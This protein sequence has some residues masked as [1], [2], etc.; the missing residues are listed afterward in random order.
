VGH[1]HSDGACGAGQ[2]QA[3]AETRLF[4]RHPSAP[5]HTFSA[6]AGLRLTFNR[7]HDLRAR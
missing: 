4:A 7:T 3:F 2:L 6:P 1:V 5:Q